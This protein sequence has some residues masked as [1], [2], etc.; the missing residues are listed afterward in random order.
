MPNSALPPH[1]LV[2]ENWTGTDWDTW[3]QRWM[4]NFKGMFAYGPRANQWWAKWREIPRVLVA[5]GDKTKWRIEYTDASLGDALTKYPRNPR[6]PTGYYVSTIQYWK[7]WGLVIQWPL[8]LAFHFYIDE[9]PEYPDRPGKKR[10]FFFR[11][12]ARRDADKV[13][14]FPSLF[15]GLTFN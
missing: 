10:V 5:I 6:Q 12:G 13:Y 11:I 4:L 2:K 1:L 7:R 14:W 3:Y 8:H 9:V 15:I